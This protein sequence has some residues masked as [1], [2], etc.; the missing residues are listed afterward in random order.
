[1]VKAIPGK[2]VLRIL[3]ANAD[4]LINGM[5]EASIAK[6]CLAELRQ[7]IEGSEKPTFTVKK[8]LFGLPKPPR[9]SSST[10]PFRKRS[11]RIYL[12]GDRFTKWPSLAG[13]IVSGN[14]AA[15]ALLANSKQL[16][17]RSSHV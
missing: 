9:T 7:F 16:K 12:A 17:D 6:M 1:M 11:G 10:G 15:T 2:Y 3:I 13:A 4:W 5:K 8:W 14:R